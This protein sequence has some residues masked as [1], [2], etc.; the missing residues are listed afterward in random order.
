[1]RCAAPPARPAPAPPRTS[2]APW[3]RQRRHSTRFREQH[4]QV[5]CTSMPRSTCRALALANG[6]GRAWPRGGMP[7]RRRRRAAHPPRD[8]V[9]AG[10]VGGLG[11]RVPVLPVVQQHVD[12]RLR[13]LQRVGRVVV[14]QHLGADG[15]AAHAGTAGWWW[16]CVVVRV[17]WGWGWGVQGCAPAQRS[18]ALPTGLPTVP[19]AAIA[20][21]RV[22]GRRGAVLRHRRGVS[23][24]ADLALL[25]RLPL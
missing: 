10:P 14:H 5:P 17:G 21:Q 6:S 9:V 16:R 7:G 8:A 3:V 13:A 2:C 20:A 15:P 11:P 19:S 12:A 23:T 1:M 22:L 18:G 25:A 24:P 4:A